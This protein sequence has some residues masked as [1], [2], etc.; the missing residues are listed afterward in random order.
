MAK[1]ANALNASG[2]TDEASRARDDANST[3][4]ALSGSLPDV[5][6]LKADLASWTRKREEI[7]KTGPASY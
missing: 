1:S 3:L 2:K 4:K 7:R 6:Y 5:P